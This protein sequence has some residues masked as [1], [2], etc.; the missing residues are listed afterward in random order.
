MDVAARERIKKKMPA[1]A[2][3]Q[4]LREK[5]L[6]RRQRRPSALHLDAADARPQ[7]PAP[8][9]RRAPARTKASSMAS[10]SVVDSG[11][12][13]PCQRG[14]A[15]PPL[16]ARTKAV[17]SR[18]RTNS[19]GRPAN[20]N[21][22]PAFMRATKL[23]STVPSLAPARSRPVLHHHGRVADDRADVELVLQ[24]DLPIRHA[25][26]ALRVR[27]DAA[28]AGIGREARTAASDEIENPRPVLVR[29]MLVSRG[30][31]HFGKQIVGPE[32]AAE[33]DGHAMLG[34]HVQG[35]IEAAPALD[36]FR[37]D[38]VAD[39]GRLDEFERMAWERA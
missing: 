32:A 9:T 11:I 27:H 17:W 38:R 23:S 26:H 16:A 31:A 22:S 18:K 39:R 5:R 2:R 33:R 19:S 6:W 10:A 37:G 24:R 28:E 35:R 21:L 12:R 29:E 20:Q 7:A 30:L 25:P 3:F 15:P 4:R 36:L 34:E 14:V 13:P 8:R 1:L